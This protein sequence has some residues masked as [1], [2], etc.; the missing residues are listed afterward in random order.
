MYFSLKNLC[1]YV[2]RGIYPATSGVCIMMVV[3]K[4]VCV[5]HPETPTLS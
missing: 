3:E 2:S 4:L 5:Y 1:S